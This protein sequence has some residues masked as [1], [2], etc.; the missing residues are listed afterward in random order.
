M[1]KDVRF[2][3]ATLYFLCKI[4]LPCPEL[5]AADQR[6]SPP[7]SATS[8]VELIRRRYVLSLL[9]TDPRSIQSLRSL[10]AAYAGSLTP[11]GSWTDIDYQGVGAARWS[12]VDHLQRTLLMAKAARL[13]HDAGGGNPALDAK[14]IMALRFWEERDFQNPSWWWNQIGV[15]ELTGEIACLM[16]EQLRSKELLKVVEIMKRCDWRQGDWGGANLIWAAIIQITR[17]CLEGNPSTVAE[18]YERMCEEIKIVSPAEEG[19]QQDNSFHQHGEQLYNGG[20]GLAYA[21]DIGRFSAFA[22]GT[23]FQIPEQRM[24]V[25]IS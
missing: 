15:P 5:F 24:A 6:I 8:E 20:Y 4:V 2:I 10:S 12:A 19:I 23:R 16:F 22:F 14:V 7:V 21:N 13:T 18:A 9:P 11:A 1:W 17:G 25:F 3:F